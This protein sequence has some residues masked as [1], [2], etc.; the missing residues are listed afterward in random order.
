M[1]NLSFVRLS[2]TINKKSDLRVVSVTVTP[3]VTNCSGT[4][5]ITD[6][7]LQEGPTLTGYLPHTE[8]SLQKYREG[9]GVKPPVWFNGVVRS[10]E[11][12]ILFNC[13]STS[14]PL[15]IHIYPKADMA[16]GSVSLCQGVGGQLV[17]FPDKVEADAD[18][19][20][21]AEART[22]AKD[23]VSEK[24]DGFYQYSA[25]WDSKHKVKLESGKTAR[26]LFELQE[27]QEYKPAAMTGFHFPTPDSDEPFILGVS[28]KS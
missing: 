6:V 23:G 15:D 11:T 16:D 3:T 19:A 27:M 1:A 2:A 20:L 12:V 18:L 25:A 8:T 22:C 28:T 9:G 7:Q 17:A 10:E 24:K 5:W 4:L 21:C 14:A 13:G 26:V